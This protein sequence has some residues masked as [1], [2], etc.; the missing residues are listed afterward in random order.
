MRS[1][2]RGMIGIALLWAAAA[3]AQTTGQ[4]RGRVVGDDGQAL[5]GVKV[6]A[7]TPSSGSR[8][9]T[10]GKDGQFRFP[11]LSPGTYKVTFTRESYS[12]VEKQATVRLDGTVTV[13][14]K[15]FKLS[16]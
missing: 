2:P 4:I 15:L 14:A 1:I 6:E 9:V 10:T 13:N 12:Q 5:A 8:S 3:W 11:L 16:G 7:N